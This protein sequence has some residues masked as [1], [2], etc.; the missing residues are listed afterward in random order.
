MVDTDISQQ[1]KDAVDD[2]SVMIKN[3]ERKEELPL[4]N[5][6]FAEEP[7]TIPADN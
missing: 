5:S 2:I 4:A 7:T 1:S 6:P 3:T